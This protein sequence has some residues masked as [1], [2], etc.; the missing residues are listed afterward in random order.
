MVREI[1]EK[2]PFECSN[3][4][5]VRNEIDVIDREIVRLLSTRLGYVKE[6]VKYKDG[7]PKGIE[8][9][10]RRKEVLLSRRDWAVEA[11]LDPDVVEKM[12]EMLVQ[13]FIDEEKKYNK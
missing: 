2:K 4:K 9:A 11:G 1:N 12:Y 7:T 6:V 5:E 13:Y 10:D 8:A 3:I